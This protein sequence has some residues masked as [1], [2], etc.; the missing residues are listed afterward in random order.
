MTGLEG[1]FLPSFTQRMLMIGASSRSQ[2]EFTDWNQ[3][4]GNCQLPMAFRVW[5]SA[6][7]LSVVP[8]C[9]KTKKK[10]MMKTTR[11]PTTH[12]RDRSSA[13]SGGWTTALAPE[14]FPPGVLPASPSTFC[15]S[16]YWISP[17]TMA[18]PA[19]PKA[20]RQPLVE[21]RPMEPMARTKY[22]SCAMKPR[23]SGAMSAP[24]LMPM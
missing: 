13:V 1:S 19:A 12:M 22:G 14:V 5:S 2:I 8:A 4:E 11:M 15:C 9:S 3:V 7:R 16:E 6:N 21:A 23:I 17:S 20:Q 10:A 18:R 24:M